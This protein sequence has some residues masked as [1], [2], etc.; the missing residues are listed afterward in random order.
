MATKRKIVIDSSV[1]VKWLLS[2]N[3]DHIK[4]AQKL[5]DEIRQ[6][7]VVCFAPELVKYEIGNAILNKNVPAIISD[8][9]ID[10]FY[11]LPVNFIAE[12]NEFAYSSFQ[13]A[14]EY[15]ITYYDASFISLAQQENAILVTDNIKHQGKASN[16]KVISLKDY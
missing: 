4:Q 5:L 7:K 8:L 1:I 16:I 11:R 12:T 10:T 13:I 15:K 2:Q 3:E 14:A 6:G 9:A